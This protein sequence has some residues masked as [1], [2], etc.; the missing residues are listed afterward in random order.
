VGLIV[1]QVAVRAPP[2]CRTARGERSDESVELAAGPP[3]DAPK[4]RSTLE[5]TGGSYFAIIV[6]RDGVDP[7][8]SDATEL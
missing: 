8:V 5:L 3:G 4:G 7:V 1:D 2:Q 6:D